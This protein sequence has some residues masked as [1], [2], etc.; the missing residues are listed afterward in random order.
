MNTLFTSPA[1]GTRPTLPGWPGSDFSWSSLPISH[2]VLWIQLRTDLPH[3]PFHPTPRTHSGPA[4]SPRKVHLRRT[5]RVCRGKER[6]GVTARMGARF[7]LPRSEGRRERWAAKGGE[8]GGQWVRGQRGSPPASW[9]CPWGAAAPREGSLAWCPQDEGPGA[10]SGKSLQP[11]A[12]PGRQQESCC[13]RVS[14]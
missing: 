14:S 2:R 5:W 6:E 3:L 10:A 9:Q 13:H 12:A 8:R 7:P 1:L 11:K 4:S